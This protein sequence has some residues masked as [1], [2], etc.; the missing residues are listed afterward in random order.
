MDETE[1]SMKVLKCLMENKDSIA[2]TSDKSVTKQKAGKKL[3]TII[4]A[5]ELPVFEGIGALK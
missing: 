3:K 2:E 4:C 5:S 1:L